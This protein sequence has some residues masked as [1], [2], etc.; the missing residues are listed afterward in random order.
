MG[1]DIFDELMEGIEYV[2]ELRKAGNKAKLKEAVGKMTAKLKEAKQARVKAKQPERKLPHSGLPVPSQPGV[3][4]RGGSDSRVLGE[5][6]GRVMPVPGAD[7][8]AEW[9]KSELLD[10]VLDEM[11]KGNIT[12]KTII[13]KLELGD[14]DFMKSFIEEL[15]KSKK[16]GKVP[17]KGKKGKVKAKAPEGLYSGKEKKEMEKQMGSAAA[18]GADVGAAVGG[19]ASGAEAVGMSAPP[20]PPAT[21][22]PGATGPVSDTMST[23]G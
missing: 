4:A 12:D 11:K 19:A 9:N 2:E 17:A 22:G 5:T 15:Q 1:R 13:T 16:K 18:G 23:A 10:Y 6:G 3:G 14:E 7:K 21:T 8:Q 20:P